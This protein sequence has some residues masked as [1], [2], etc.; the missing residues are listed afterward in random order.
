MSNSRGICDGNGVAGA[1]RGGAS[2][3][4]ADDTGPGGKGRR[5]SLTRLTSMPRN[6]ALTATLAMHFE[7]IAGGRREHGGSSHEP[8]HV[9]SRP[10]TSGVRSALLSPAFE[11]AG[12]VLWRRPATALHESRDLV[13][14]SRAA[15]SPDPLRPL[16]ADYEAASVRRPGLTGPEA[17]T[18]WRSAFW[19]SPL[20][21]RVSRAR[22]RPLPRGEPANDR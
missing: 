12:G 17:T 20:A 1:L 4:A 2:R 19:S 21:A 15:P 9:V 13:R 10:S 11:H 5:G 22:S 16:S 6:T 8:S 18:A 7:G 3:A 14:E